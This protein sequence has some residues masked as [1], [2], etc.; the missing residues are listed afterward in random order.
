[1]GRVKLDSVDRKILSALQENGRITNVDL[2]NKVGITA[3]PCLRRVRALEEAGYIEDYHA[4]LSA[5]KLGYTITVFA[6]VRLHN[7]S[8][9]DLKAFE[10]KVHSWPLV[11]DCYLLNGDIDFILKIVAKDLAE[12]QQFLTSELVHADNVASVRTSLTVSSVKHVPGI[13]LPAVE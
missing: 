9:A 12:F 10:A 8:E 4:K 7:Q 6:M 13:P 3:P 2:A 11:R 5:E 1:M